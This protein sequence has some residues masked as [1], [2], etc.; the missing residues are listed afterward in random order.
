MSFRFHIP[1]FLEYLSFRIKEESRTYDADICF[2]IIL[3]FTD[4]R[5]FL[6]E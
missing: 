1:P 3:F 6:I 5:E 4:D 2:S